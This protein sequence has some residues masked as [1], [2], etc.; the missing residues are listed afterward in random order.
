MVADSK[1]ILVGGVD[2]GGVEILFSFGSVGS[3]FGVGRL[4]VFFN[5]VRLEKVFA[6]GGGH[7]PAG[8]LGSLPAGE[9]LNVPR[10]GTFNPVGARS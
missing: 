6:S 3:G 9:N 5:T 2:I 4:E 8:W 7:S 10:G 1:K